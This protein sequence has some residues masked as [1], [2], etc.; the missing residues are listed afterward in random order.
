MKLKKDLIIELEEVKRKLEILEEEVE[1]YEE[2]YIH[3]DDVS[4]Y[5][6]TNFASDINDYGNDKLKNLFIEKIAYCTEIGQLPTKQL[7]LV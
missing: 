3:V 7:D 5:D 2:N 1:D 6:F 4:L